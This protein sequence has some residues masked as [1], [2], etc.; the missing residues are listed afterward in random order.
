MA[1]IGDLQYTEYYN[2]FSVIVGLT[3][4]LVACVIIGICAILIFR[5]YKRRAVTKCKMEMSKGKKGKLTKPRNVR[6]LP[7]NV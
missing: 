5:R 4:G 1:Y 7:M 3:A 2:N 6:L